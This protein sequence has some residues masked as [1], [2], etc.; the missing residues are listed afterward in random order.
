METRVPDHPQLGLLLRLLHQ[1]WT[2]AV[3]AALRDAGF[4]D[5]RPPHANVFTFVQPHGIQVSELTR[6]AHVRKQT[7]AQAVEELEQLG[8]VER[9]PDPSDRRARLVFLTPRGESVR[10]I[11]MAAGRRVAARWAELTSPQ[12]IAS[13]ERS[14]QALLSRLQN[15]VDVDVDVDADADPQVGVRPKPIGRGPRAGP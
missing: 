6:L 13:L 4:G 9:R 7:M 8:Y 14:L 5:I 15:D 12:Q 11:A 1:H 3:D 2:L 10:P